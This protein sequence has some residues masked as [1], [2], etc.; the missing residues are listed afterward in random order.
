MGVTHTTLPLD[1]PQKRG[2]QVELDSDVFI[3]DPFC[4]PVKGTKYADF[5]RGIISK[6]YNK[7]FGEYLF[8]KQGPN[9]S[10][11][12][13]TLFFAPPIPED[14]IDV[15]Y[16]TEYKFGNHYWP[17]VL[18]SI[19]FIPDRSFP[20][21]TRGPDNSI[22]NATRYYT[23]EVYIPS[24]SEGTLFTIDKFIYPYE[25]EIPQ[26]DTP[27]PTRVSWDMLG[28]TG[29]FEECLHPDII[30]PATRTAFAKYTAGESASAGG[31]LN[32]Q[33]FPATNFTEWQDYVVSDT[34]SFEN[35][36]YIRVRITVTPPAEPEIIIR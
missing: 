13:P 6:D 29:S 22:I 33:R 17:P 1:P 16:E 25:P 12:N 7:K 2:L 4:I 19:S 35:G 34:F 14:E 32:G 20:N 36:A 9:S 31:S 28:N 24:V 18:K 30:I 26:H 5:P 15:P 27:T 3:N 21:S 23:R 8:T 11:G 10:R